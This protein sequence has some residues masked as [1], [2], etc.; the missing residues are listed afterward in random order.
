MSGDSRG[1]RART[2]VALAMAM[3]MAGPGLSGAQEADRTDVAVTNLLPSG[4]W[5]PPMSLSESLLST[6]PTQTNRTNRNGV[7]SNCDLAPKAPPGTLGGT[8]VYNAYAFRN[9]TIDEQ[10]VQVTC[11]QLDGTINVFVTVYAGTFDPA[12]IAANYL[13]DAGFSAS[14]R[15]PLS[16]SFKAGR[17]QNYTIVVATTSTNTDTPY[18]LTV[19]TRPA[20]GGHSVLLSKPIRILDSRAG[21]GAPLGGDGP[22]APGATKTIQVTGTSVGGVSVPQG[23]VAVIGNVTAASATGPGNLRL[24]AAGSALPTV[25][26]INYSPAQNIANGVTVKLSASGQMS[27]RV[28]GAGSTHV[29]FDVTGYIMSPIN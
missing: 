26:N 15:T 28:G 10:C 7:T 19:R 2:T 29:I 27:I 18:S 8:F 16:F 6:G 14:A 21:S 12:D 20:R 23:A 11:A 1:V 4:I 13:A 9:D 24:Y 25:S 22:Y 17:G 5:A 3:A